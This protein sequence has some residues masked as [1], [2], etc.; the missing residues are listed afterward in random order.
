VLVVALGIVPLGRA[1]ARLGELGPTVAFLAAVLLLADL[2]DRQGLFEAAG[3]RACSRRP[4]T[5]WRG[6]AADARSRCS[7]S[8]RD[9]LG[10]DGRAQPRHDRRAADPGR[11]RDRRARG[12]AA[13]AARV[14]VQPP[15][16]LGLAAA[17]GLEP[18]Q[19]ARLPGE[20]AV[21]PRLRGRDALPW[22]A[23]VASEWLVL[24]RFFAADLVGLGQLA[25]EERATGAPVYALV[26]F[27]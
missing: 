20:R 23:A 18:D 7:R 16:Q 5:G 2:C 25:V 3:H 11:A 22:L 4:A 27:G 8:F 26:V 19:P 24:R 1:G 12:T 14:R 21:V 15:G 13:P 10:R 6:P 9:R 17:A